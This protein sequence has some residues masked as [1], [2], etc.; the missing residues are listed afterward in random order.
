MISFTKV[1]LPYGWMGNMAPYPLLFDNKHWLTSEAL[2]QSMRFNNEE[3]KELIR[4]QVSP[5]A[6]KMKAKKNRE[7]YIIEPMS[8][9]DVENMKL[10]VKLKL[11]QHPKL[12][13]EL[14]KTGENYIFENIGARNGE[15]HLFWG[16]KMIN[17]ELVG[18][19]MMGKIW[20]EFR[21][22]VKN[23]LI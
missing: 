8:D 7:H 2:F 13:T 5:M 16:A 14:L 3:I 15:R 22:K 1:K 18:N 6:A 17:G 19:N 11:E 21:D 9:Q 20:M 12:K 4:I 10:C 23:N